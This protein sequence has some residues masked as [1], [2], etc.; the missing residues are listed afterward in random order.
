MTR[1]PGGERG[2]IVHAHLMGPGCVWGQ[3][4]HESGG[5]AE[6]RGSRSG[7]ADPAQEGPGEN[8]AEE[9][10]AGLSRPDAP[11]TSLT[12]LRPATSSPALELG[13][14]LLAPCSQACRLELHYTASSPGSACGRMPGDAWALL[15][16]NLFPSLR[17]VTSNVPGWDCF[18]GER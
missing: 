3:L 7:R 13:L 4:P 2:L 6:E 18:S 12:R 1:T 5:L 17:G 9:G 14:P 11:V 15:R 10:G 16:I 8:T